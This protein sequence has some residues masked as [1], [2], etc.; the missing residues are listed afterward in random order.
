MRRV[1]D[2]FDDRAGSDLADT[3]EE[4]EPEVTRG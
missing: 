1:R 4:R 2:D 3:E